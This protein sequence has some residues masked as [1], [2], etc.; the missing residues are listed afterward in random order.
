MSTQA[1]PTMVA[2]GRG[3]RRGVVI[4]HGRGGWCGCLYTLSVS[5]HHKIVLR[6][7]LMSRLWYVMGLGRCRVIMPTIEIGHMLAWWYRVMTSMRIGLV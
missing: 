1:T 7:L 3:G 4:H 6:L 5:I 2:V